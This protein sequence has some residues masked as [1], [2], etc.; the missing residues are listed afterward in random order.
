GV[1]ENGD[2]LQAFQLRTRGTRAGID[3]KVFGGQGL[4]I[5]TLES[6]F[7]G[8]RAGESGFTEDQI[9]VGGLLDARLAAVAKAVHDIPLAFPHFAQIYADSSG[10]NSVI[11]SPARKIRYATARHHGFGW[12]AALVDACAANMYALDEGSSH[13]CLPKCDG[14]RCTTLSRTDNDCVALL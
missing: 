6:H 4:L 13:A 5:A 9:Q 3:E 14:Q 2:A 10:V 8:F 11:R 12:R 1:I 7:N